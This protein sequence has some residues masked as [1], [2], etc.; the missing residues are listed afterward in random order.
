MSTLIQ[1]SFP[2]A[3]AA[4]EGER[5]IERLAQIRAGNTAEMRTEQRAKD[6]QKHKLTEQSEEQSKHI[7]KKK[8]CDTNNCDYW[9]RFN[10]AN[11]NNF[12]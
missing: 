6:R 8:I 2:I 4:K 5:E 9:R 3:A 10:F 12:H 11:L 1:A 7:D